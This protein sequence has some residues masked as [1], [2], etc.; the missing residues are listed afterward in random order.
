LQF[1][2][3]KSTASLRPR[4]SIRVFRAIRAGFRLTWSR[5]NDI[6]PLADIEL[7]SA[8]RYVCVLILLAT[9]VPAAQLATPN[10]FSARV[11]TYQE[12]LIDDIET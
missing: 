12:I 5:V 6:I 2:R 7:L 3:T 9:H 10:P 1:N 8:G 4:P 11:A